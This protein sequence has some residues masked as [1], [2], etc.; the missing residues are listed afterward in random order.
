MAQIDIKV[1]GSSY[2]LEVDDNETLL[3]V[4]RD[5]LDLTGAKN[6]CGYGTCGACTVVMDG[7]AVRSCVLKH[8]K[9]NGKEIITIEGISDGH[10]LHPV[11]E[12]FIEAGAVQCGFCSPGYIM[13]LYALYNENL[14]A[15]DEE[16]KKILEKHLCRCTGYET[17]W[18]AAKMAQKKMKEK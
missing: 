8:P 18:E 7:K 16:I 4:L 14:E 1:N 6:G 10:K 9:Y 2:K 11:Q 17:I 3:D 15:S 5:R 13:S 12:A